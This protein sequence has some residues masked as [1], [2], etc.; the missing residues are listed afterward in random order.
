M[1]IVAK[2]LKASMVFKEVLVNSSVALNR[3]RYLDVK[4]NP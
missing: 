3:K 2:R 4:I 1:Y